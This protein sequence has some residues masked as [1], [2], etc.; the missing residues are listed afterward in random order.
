MF[1]IEPVGV[2]NPGQWHWNYKNKDGK[3]VASSRDH[4]AIQ[5]LCMDGLENF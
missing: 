2:L 5:E 4:Y 3:I 1:T